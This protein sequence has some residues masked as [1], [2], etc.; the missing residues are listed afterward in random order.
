MLLNIGVLLFG[1]PTWHLMYINY[2]FL[3]AFFDI[4]IFYN[5]NS[6]HDLRK[7]LTPKQLRPSF[8]KNHSKLPFVLHSFNKN[9][10][11]KNLEYKP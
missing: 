4:L 6:V 2:S 9:F 10:K 3:H 7:K 1:S 8:V 5:F 11:K